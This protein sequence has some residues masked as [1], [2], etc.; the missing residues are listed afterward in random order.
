[1]MSTL[2]SRH[3]VQLDSIVS[4]PG[5]SALKPRRSSTPRAPA[6][7]LVLFGAMRDLAHKKVLRGPYHMVWHGKVVIYEAFVEG[8]LEAPNHLARTV[9]ELYFEPKYEELKPRTS[10][11]LFQCVHFGIQ[12]NGSHPTIQG[13]GQAG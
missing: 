13:H 9:H 1:M 4:A 11:S 10:W 5:R 12:G 7:L 8:R 3:L 6:D 2:S